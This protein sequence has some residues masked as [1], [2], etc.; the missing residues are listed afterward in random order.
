MLKLD[1]TGCGEAA[2]CNIF[3]LTEQKERCR[4]V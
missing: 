3:C 2:T 1:P 4:D